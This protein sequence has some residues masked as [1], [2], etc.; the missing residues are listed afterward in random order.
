MRRWNKCC[1]PWDPW[2]ATN[3]APLECPNFER[4]EKELFG[5]TAGEMLEEILDSPIEICEKYALKEISIKE[6]HPRMS[7]SHRHKLVQ[8]ALAKSRNKMVRNYANRQAQYFKIVQWQE[9]Q[10]EMKQYRK[11]FEAARADAEKASFIGQG[12]NRVGT[13]VEFSDGSRHV[14][15]GLVGEESSDNFDDKVVVGYRSLL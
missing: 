12:L 2:C 13:L 4:Q 15:G 14:L 5:V 1:L 9:S 3:L 7:R 10:P 8:E 11:D 6:A